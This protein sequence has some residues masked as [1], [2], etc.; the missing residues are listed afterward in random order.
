MVHAY[1]KIKTEIIMDVMVI[2]MQMI[3][4]F[5]II[6][7][8][9]VLYLV[10]IIDK[11]LNKKLTTLILNVTTPAMILASVFNS[12][13]NQS[14]SDV[15]FVFGIAIV[16]YI[17]LPM[18]GYVIAKIIRAPKEQL[19]VYIFMNVF[20]NVGFM[21]FPVMKAI[22]GDDAV[23][24]TAIF[25]MLFSLVLFSVGRA[26][27]NFGGKEKVKIELKSFITPG[28]ICSI[29][30]IL[31]YFTGIVLPDVIVSTL[32]MV[33]DMTT[34]IAM[35]IIGST[36]ATIPLKDVFTDI[37]VYVFT[38][39]KQV[40]FPII[41]Y[42]VLNLIIK[43]PLI[44]GVTLIV[45]SMPV[46]NSVVLFAT[47]YGKDASLGAKSIFMTTLLSILTIPLIV[48]LYLV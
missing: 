39:V 38:L 15:I 20:S 6:G 5:L 2:F 14:Q 48:A 46:G 42:P 18:I 28:I 27:M 4:L 24:F 8:G 13:S 34:P 36:L 23:F 40:I 44:L 1:L 29:L 7:L 21:G 25:N 30:A 19:G 22:F 33:G 32:N 12:T 37:R 41:I 11:D 43:D 16:T 45:L 35:L 9:Y 47:E 3:Q 31:F 10:N 26:I 17:L